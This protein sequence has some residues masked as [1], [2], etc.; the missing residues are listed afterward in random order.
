MPRCCQQFKQKQLVSYLI[1]GEG[2]W[3]GF[4]LTLILKQDSPQF[5]RNSI[6]LLP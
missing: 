6:D 5:T 3:V 2:G 4:N 1:G